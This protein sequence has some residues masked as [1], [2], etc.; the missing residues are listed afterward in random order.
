MKKKY[1]LLFLLLWLCPWLNVKAST[2]L[3]KENLTTALTSVMT[4]TDPDDTES[5][6][7]TNDNNMSVTVSDKTI[8]FISTDDNSVIYSVNYDLST[9]P[10]SFTANIDITN[11]TTYL[12]YQSDLQKLMMNMICSAAVAVVEGADTKSAIQFYIVKPYFAL[13]QY[14]SDNINQKYLIV[15]D[16]KVATTTPPTGITLVGQS[17]FPTYALAIFATAFP[18]G[19][20]V[21]D[22]NNFKS[23]TNAITDTSVSTTSAKITSLIQMNLTANYPLLSSHLTDTYLLA[24]PVVEEEVTTEPVTEETENPATGSNIPAPVIIGTVL[25]LIVFIYFACSSTKFYRI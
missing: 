18:E 15:S 7:I 13:T 22:Q 1:L 23:V 5:T 12:E 4:Y 24:L 9:T 19:T 3:T 16:D 21:N 20:N 6:S 10:P 11:A 17:E 25:A 8:D 2:T 14:V